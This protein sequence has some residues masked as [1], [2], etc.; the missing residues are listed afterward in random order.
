MRCG[1]PL[2]RGILIIRA[3]LVKFGLLRDEYVFDPHCVSCSQLR[4]RNHQDFC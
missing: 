3:V 4:Y 1:G 2:D